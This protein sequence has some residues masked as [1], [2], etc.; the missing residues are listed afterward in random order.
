MIKTP[1]SVVNKE[2]KHQNS[3]RNI[4]AKMLI[5]VN[6]IQR[7]GKIIHHDYG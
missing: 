1:I 7:N 5:L 4:R 2:T 3:F 6:K